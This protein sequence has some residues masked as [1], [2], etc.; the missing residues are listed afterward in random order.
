MKSFNKIAI[1]GVGLIGGSIG[2]AVKK[3]RLAKQVVG[4]FRRPSS[5]KK[6]LKARAIDRGTLDTAEG[7]SGA[8]L[9]IIATPVGLVPAM[10]KK[11]MPHM[12]KGAILTDV[13]SVKGFVEREVVGSVSQGIKF[14]GSHPMA[15][16]EKSGVEF[17]EADLFKGALTILTRTRR[18]D[19]AALRRIESFWKALGSRVKI[20]SPEEHDAR[21]ALVSHLPHMV[22]QS[23]C[24][25]LD[26]TS[27]PYAAS[28]FKD[29]TRIAASDPAMWTDIAATN[30]PAIEKALDLLIRDLC[31]LKL[32]LSEGD[33]RSIGA[34]INQAKRIRER[35]E[36]GAKGRRA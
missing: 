3:R 30:A 12:A 34:R 11:A 19:L 8:D 29:T 31:W 32:L 15:G 17:A 33:V 23:L 26:E 24:L 28:G 7:V 35:L 18:T 10:A 16:S 4:V 36:G 13:G 22:A 25:I 14:V 20:L 21:V 6:A 1:I 2:L 27:E 9:V 5:L